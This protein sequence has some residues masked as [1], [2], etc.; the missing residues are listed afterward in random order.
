MK[1]RLHSLVLVASSLA[2]ALATARGAD[3]NTNTIKFSDPAKPGT[4]KISIGRG[5][6][7]VQGA[8]TNE[9]TIKSESRAVTNNRRKDGMRVISASSSYALGE[10]D[11]VVTLDATANDWGK[12]SGNFTLTVPRNTTILVQNAWGGDFKA[13]SIS[14][15]IELNAMHGEIRLDDVSGG[16]VVGTMNGE[17]RANIRE[18]REGKPLSFTSMNGEITLRLPE[19]AKANVRVR[20]QNGVV[21][22]D[23]DEGTLVTK[24]E[25]SPRGAVSFRNTRGLSSDEQNAIREATRAS[26]D[27]VRAAL[28]AVKQGLESSKLES[29]E[30]KQRLE[31]AKRQLSQIDSERRDEEKKAREMAR[32][33]NTAPP[34]PPAKPAAPSKTVT[35]GMVPPVPPVK[36][37]IPTISGG[38]LVTGTLNG[39]GPEISISTMNGDVTIRKLDKK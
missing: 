18:L 8:D 22:T 6:L 26:A 32:S 11:N 20:T 19:S 37:A 21:L 35:I 33:G 5:D 17:I 39:G 10:K 14:G 30:A 2:L 38:K 36:I 13:S 28:E 7:T 16:V 15:D 1:S 24:T 23:F 9:V 3:D 4:V 34:A 12:G 27:A 31:D 25:A 29:E